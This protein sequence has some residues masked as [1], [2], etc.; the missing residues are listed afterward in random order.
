MRTLWKLAAIAAA[1]LLSAGAARAEPVAVSLEDYAFDFPTYG[2]EIAVS[3]TTRNFQD[4]LTA[5]D[6][7]TIVDD[8]Y[9]L[10]TLIDRM[11]RRDRQKFIAFF[12][13]HCIVGFTRD[14]CAIT[15]SGDVELDENMKMIFRMSSATISMGAAGWSNMGD[16]LGAEE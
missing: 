2:Y 10:K 14:A 16:D 15:A 6:Y 5:D 3:G 4:K 13:E 7:I 1:V 8:G 9:N 11:G 12:N